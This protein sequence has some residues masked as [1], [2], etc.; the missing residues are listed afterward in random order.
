VSGGPGGVPE[1]P[2]GTALK[3]VAGRNV[4][5]GFESRPLCVSTAYRMGRVRVMPLMGLELV[6]A[7]VASLIA[8]NAPLVILQVALALVAVSAVVLAVLIGVRPPAV[9]WLYESS[10]RSR[11]RAGRN[12]AKFVGEW[13][14]VSDAEVDD[15]MLRLTLES[16][17]TQSLPLMLIPAKDRER[18]LRDIYERLNAAHGYR[19][20]DATGDAAS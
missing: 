12:E 1:W 17:E 13:I 11:V 15:D 5:R 20:F 19:R 18:L 8:F 3:A 10:Y 16:G 14:N 6:V 9:V 4:S 2:I 7:A